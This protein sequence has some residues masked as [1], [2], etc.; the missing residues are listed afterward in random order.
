MRYTRDMACRGTGFIALPLVAA[1][2]G[3]TAEP[4]SAARQPWPPIPA[5]GSTF[6]HFGEEHLSDEDGMRIFPKV[7]RQSRRYRPDLV[8]ASADKADDGTT[9]NLRAWKKIMRPFDRRGI[10]Y[11]PGVGN[12]DRKARPGFPSGVDPMGSLANYQGVFATRPYPF[13]DA[14]PYPVKRLSPKRRPAS[15]PAGA[16][17]HYA[18]EYGPARWIFIDNSCFSIIS[19]DSLQSPSFP[20]SDGNQGQYDFLRSEAAKAEEEGDLAFVVMHMPT[21]D[22]RPGHT[23]PTPGPHTMGEGLSPD[24]ALFEQVAA[25]SGIDGVFA[26][27]I[28][29]MWQYQAGGVPY[30]TDGGAGGEV[31]VGP[32]E[33]TGVDYGYW[34]GFRVINVRGERIRTDPVPVFA[35]SGIEITGPDE[36]RVGEV[37]K[38]SAQGQQPTRH[39]PDVKLEL[40]APSS[41]RPNLDNLPTPA[42]IWTSV[43]RR[44]L[45]PVPAVEDDPR[46][47]P[48]RQTTSGEFEAICPGKAVIRIKSG[49]SSARHVVRVK[50]SRARDC[51]S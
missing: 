17:S 16:S 47:N 34:H 13:G 26:G 39:G 45:E 28:K 44:R 29:G 1:V 15:D 20:D 50:G 21:Q 36:V 18:V 9:E 24:N 40:R 38:F 23:Q 25:S 11:F 33:E 10:P 49:W 43:H 4:A 27:H 31:Y 19:C 14:D 7:V 48:R 2:L 30:F 41:S 42:F 5:K 51:R 32:S 6:V 22:D 3:L 12:H 35:R 8:T 46:R 37:A